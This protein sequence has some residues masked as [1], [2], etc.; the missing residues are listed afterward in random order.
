MY[1]LVKD[2]GAVLRVEV[3]Q[4]GDGCALD[5]FEQADRFEPEDAEGP[6]DQ[7][8]VLRVEGAQLL[9]H[10][11]HLLRHEPEDGLVAKGIFAIASEAQ[12]VLQ[13]Q[14]E[15][16][17]SFHTHEAIAAVLVQV[18]LGAEAEKGLAH[19]VTL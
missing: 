9:G 3:R 5:A 11:T 14:G 16:C 17:E 7:C 6:H 18:N 10:R 12:F 8:E 1:Y 13:R 15:L 2:V 4:L 19:Q